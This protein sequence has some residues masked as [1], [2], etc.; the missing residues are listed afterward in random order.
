MLL[1]NT[2]EGAAA[3]GAR[4]LACAGEFGLINRVMGSHCG[5]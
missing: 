4:P 5:V 2:G 3:D 1:L